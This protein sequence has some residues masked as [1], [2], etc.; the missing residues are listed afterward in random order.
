MKSIGQAPVG[1]APAIRTSTTRARLSRRAF[2]RGLGASAALLPMLESE[3]AHGATAAPPKRIVTIAWSNGVAMPNFYPTTSDPTASTILAPLAPVKA[4]TTLV[5]G[6]DFKNMLDTSHNYDG[7]FSFPTM[8]TG[9]YKNTGGQNCTAT[10]ASIDQVVST[11]VAKTV[12]L[13]APLVVITPQG[14]STSYRADGSENTGETKPDRL[15]TNLFSS[16]SMPSTMVSAQQARRKSVIDYLL[17]ELQGFA[18]RR[19]TDDKALINAHLDSIRQVEQSLTATAT[20]GAGCMPVSPGAPSAYQDQIKAFNDLV[21]MAFR[22]DITR[23]VSMSWADDGGSGPYTM[24]FLNL[25][26]PTSMAIGEV[27]NIAHEGSAGYAKKTIIDTWYMQQLAY[28]A[29]KLD[30][31]TEGTGTILDNSLIIMGNDMNEGSYHAVSNIPY[32]LVGRAGGAL[33]AGRIVKVGKWATAS[34]TYWTSGNTG[35]PHN[36]LLAT[37]SNLFDVP[38]TSFGTGY[39]GTLTALA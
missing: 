18:Q 28:L 12:N 31:S 34:G 36:Q 29:T 15:F 24:P 27:H 14:K 7:H 32:V 21:A 3:W 10:G 17:P 19:G 4:K 26:D 16:V 23:A 5:A 37:I 1:K 11:N 2:L 20:G 13:P 22:C 25:N 33:Q 38:A 39:S 8:F 30:G 35:V 6:V 9:T